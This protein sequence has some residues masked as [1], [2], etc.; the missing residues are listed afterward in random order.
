MIPIKLQISGF[1]SYRDPAELDFSKF[2]LACISGPN[3][4]GKSSLLDAITFALFGQARARGDAL[5]NSHKDVNAAQVTFTFSYEGNTYRVQRTTPRDE[6]SLLE[7]HIR[8]KEGKW[9]ALTEHTLRETETLIRKTLRLDYETF[10]NASF[11]LQG[12]ADQFTQQN[13]S[14]RKRILS[15][16]LGLE[17]WDQYRLKAAE[18]RKALEDQIAVLQGRLQEIVA[19]LGE[20]AQR[21]QRLKELQAQLDSLS[22][23]R[24]TQERALEE[25]RARAAAIEQQSTLV[26]TLAASV[27]RGQALLVD[28]TTRLSERQA[29]QAGFA[30]LLGRSKEIEQAYKA[31]QTARDELTQWDAIASRFREQELKRS[32]PLGQIEAERARLETELEALEGE[33]ANLESLQ[34]SQSALQEEHKSLQEE[35]AKTEKEIANRSKLEEN[36]KK[37]REEETRVKTANPI[38]MAEMKTLRAKIDLMEE[39]K[40]SADCPTCGQ[41][42]TEAH[43]ASVIAELTK[44]GKSVAAKYRANEKA[45]VDTAKRVEQLEQSLAGL[46]QKEEDLRAKKLNEGQLQSRLE[47]MEAVAKEWKKK[48]GPRLE[49]I[50]ARL[51]KEDY[52]LQAHKELAA[53]D[54]ELKATG[55]DATEHD[56]AR[57]REQGTRAAEEDQR[58]LEQARAASK[59]L[60]REIKDLQKQITTQEKEL[61]AQEESHRQAAEALASVQTGLPDLQSAERAMLEM[62][63]QENK[64]RASLGAAQQEVEVLDTL[65]ARRKDYEAQREEL[66]AQ[67]SQFQALERAFGKDGVQAMLIEQALPQIE[68]KANQ[69]L[70]RLS[71]GGMNIRFVTQEQY[72]DSK[73][74]DLRETLDIQISDGAGTREYEMFSGG[75]AFRINFAIRLALSEVLAQRAGA[76]LQTLVVDEGFGS[77]D[78]AGRQRLIEAIN[79][80]R[81]DFAK[82][83]VITHVE[84]LKDAFPTK[85]EVEKGARGSTVR[86]I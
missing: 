66:G 85:I 50:L 43:R 57:K 67:V 84:A 29:E 12:K 13:P 5:I 59:P 38:M 61:A 53:F 25:L 45:V 69:I 82:I 19:E 17:I 24:A 70:D 14:D 37:E 47:E 35:L 18:R 44:E 10:V 8:N 65:R 64:T 21:K 30:D 58:A 49:E 3:G 79:M 76:R 46:S 86:V 40:G 20:E 54:A 7:F 81:Q 71:A 33:R 83:L 80:V 34:A 73:R 41:P 51:E 11:F 32:G 77:Q 68:T 26:A 48:R 1:L 23:A 6:R 55:Y 63:E 75:E 78:E 36:L 74:K 2:E 62:Q 28:L 16:V 56:A 31:W 27:E 52:A 4:A 15:S 9:K 72:K 22:K 39:A 42:L 60:E